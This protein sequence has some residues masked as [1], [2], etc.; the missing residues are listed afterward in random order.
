MGFRRASSASS[1]R[2]LQ[3]VAVRTGVYAGFGLSVV[4]VAW[5]LAANRVSSLETLTEERNLTAAILLGGL[6]LVPVF[7]FLLMPAKLW[8]SSLIAWAIFSATYASFS[9]Y[10]ASLREH[11]GAFQLFVLGAVAYMIVAT[12]SWVGNIIWRARAGRPAHPRHFP[13]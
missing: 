3:N 11:F 6:A 4:F 12:V 10:F 1:G 8:I 5:I 7:R 9:A 13:G 2:P